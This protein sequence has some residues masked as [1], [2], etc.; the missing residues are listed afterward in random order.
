M[1]TLGGTVYT[2]AGGGIATVNHVVLANTGGLGLAANPVNG[3]HYLA[4]SSFSQGVTEINPTNGAHRV[5]S[6]AGTD[7][8]SVTPDGLIAYAAQFNNNH[9]VGYRISDGAVVKDFDFTGIGRPDGSSAGVGP[10]GNFIFTT[11]SGNGALYQ[12]DLT[13]GVKTLIATSTVGTFG[14]FITVDPTNGTLF[15]PEN[16]GIYRISL[17]GGGGFAGTSEPSTIVTAAIGLAGAALMARR[18]RSARPLA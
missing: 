14:D 18:R 5:I 7:G 6:T 15:V 17:Q 13:T 8:V 11:I 12:A 10:L 3:L 9:L 2:V 1:T 16:D 4:D